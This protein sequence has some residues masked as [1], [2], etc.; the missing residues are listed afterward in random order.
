M[1]TKERTNPCQGFNE[2]ICPI[3]G[4]IFMPAVYHQYKDN[5]YFYCSWTCYNK[6]ERPEDNSS[7]P[8]L[9]YTLDGEFVARHRNALA[10][11][12]SVACTV[13]YLQKCLAGKI[14]KAKGYV[15][16]YE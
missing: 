16:K 7:R 13:K 10:A 12:D 1:I 2:A 8:V 4:K 9:Q 5:R 3:C 15:W 14:E 6:R 11:A